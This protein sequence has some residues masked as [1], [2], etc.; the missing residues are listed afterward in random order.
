VIQAG[1]ADGLKLSIILI[2]RALPPGAELILTIQDELLILCRAEQVEEVNKIVVA[3]V[4]AAYRIALGE[5]LKVPIV[6][7]PLIIKNWSEK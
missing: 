5:P 1:C 3:A 2:V 6:I 4:V 7:K